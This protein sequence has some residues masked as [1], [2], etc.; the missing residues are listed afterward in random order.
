MSLVS[1]NLCNPG[2]VCFIQIGLIFVYEMALKN[3]SSGLV[4]P[5]DQGTDL[6]GKVGIGIA[7]MEVF[8]DSEFP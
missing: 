1:I 6:E 7:G 3:L 5:V 8:T 2:L 4:L